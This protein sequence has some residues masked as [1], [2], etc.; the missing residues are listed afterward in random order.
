M[1]MKTVTCYIK[2]IKLIFGYKRTD[3]VTNMLVELNLPNFNTILHNSSVIFKLQI[4][5]TCNAVAAATHYLLL[6]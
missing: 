6:Q 5:N 3:S 2:C 4:Y 1:V